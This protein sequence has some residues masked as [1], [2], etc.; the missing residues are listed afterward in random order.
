MVLTCSLALQGA[1]LPAVA[2]KSAS[3][4]E[5]CRLDRNNDRSISFEEFAACEFY[6]LERV[7]ELPYVEPNDLRLQGGIRLSDD[8]LKAYLFKKADKNK[9]QMINRKEW[10]EF[11]N[12]LMD[13]EPEGGASRRHR[14]IR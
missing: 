5:F 7:K 14:D 9:D 12:S 6:K 10:E 11:Y 1:G 2:G 4:Q 13:M 8:E 3:E